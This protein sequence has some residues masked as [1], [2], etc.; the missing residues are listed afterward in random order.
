MPCGR[1]KK[2]QICVFAAV[3]SEPDDCAQVPASNAIDLFMDSAGFLDHLAPFFYFRRDVI[4]KLGRRARCGLDALSQKFVPDVRTLECTYEESVD[5]D[6]DRLHS[7]ARH[8][9]AIPRNQFVS[10]YPALGNRRDIR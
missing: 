5:L 10:L 2:F 9:N 6:D 8:Q 4:G 3:S 7:P 1:L